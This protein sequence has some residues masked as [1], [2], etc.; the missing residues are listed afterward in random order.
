MKRFTLMVSFLTLLCLNIVAQNFELYENK[1]IFSNMFTE[2]EYRTSTSV[3]PLCT[4]ELSWNVAKRV[5]SSGYTLKNQQTTSPLY[6][7][8]VEDKLYPYI[9]SNIYDYAQIVSAKTG[10]DIEVVT[11]NSRG[12][13]MELRKRL[14]DLRP[15]LIGCFFIGDVPYAQYQIENDDNSGVNT[16]FPC[17]LYFM[18]LDGTWLDNCSN[19]G[20]EGRFT[21]GAD[22]IF[23]WHIG[24]VAPDIFIGR[25][26][27][28]YS[29]D[30]RPFEQLVNQSLERL[31]RYWE[32]PDGIKRKA[33]SYIN[34]DW[35]T[36]Y[37][38]ARQNVSRLSPLENAGFTID[39]YNE[40]NNP[41]NI[42][43]GD[44][45][46]K[47]TS[48]QYSFVHLWAHSHWTNHMFGQ[49]DINESYLFQSEIYASP[50]KA[51]MYNLFCCS[52]TRWTEKSYLGGAYLFGPKSN[53]LALVGST[54]VGSMYDSAPFHGL[55][56]YGLSIGE[57]YFTWWDMRPHLMRTN[58]HSDEDIS[59]YYGLT[60]L[61]D[62]LVR[63][64]NPID[65]Y[66]QD[67]PDDDG[68]MPNAMDDMKYNFWE[69]QDIWIRNQRDGGTEHQNPVYREGKPV[70]V[71]ARIRNR[72]AKT[73][74]Q[75]ATVTLRWSQ[76][77][78]SLDYDSFCGKNKLDNGVATGGLIGTKGIPSVRPNESVVICF[79]WYI[80]DP[81][82]YQQYT[83]D[84]WHYC[85]LAEI[86][87]IQEP[88]SEKMHNLRDYVKS[89]NNVAMKNIY[90]IEVSDDD[91]SLISGVISIHNPSIDNRIYKIELETF[92]KNTLQQTNLCTKAEV[93]L[94]P[95]RMLYHS[96][97]GN[98]A[99]LRNLQLLKSEGRLVAQTDLASMDKVCLAPGE[100]GLLNVKF[101][102][103]EQMADLD[104]EYI[105][106]VLLKD[107]ETGEL[108]GGETYV[109]K[110]K[111]RPNFDVV[112][113]HK[114][115]EGAVH[116]VAQQISE[117]ATY[118]WRDSEGELLSE[119]LE[120]TTKTSAP[121]QL[122]VEAKSDGVKGE[123][124][125]EGGSSSLAGL[126]TISPN[127]AKDYLDVKVKME[128]EASLIITSVA[129]GCSYI[130]PILKEGRI[131]VG[132]LPRGK[133]L[134]SLFCKE[135]MYDKQT[136]ILE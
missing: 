123:A 107:Q 76:A 117:P 103:K 62:P 26:P 17:D 95:D 60:I 45:L 51:L 124:L 18:D 132:S 56:A 75:G 134:V 116:L 40:A 10:Y 25:L 27:Y 121:V 111:S 61:G 133:Y 59:W 131:D 119:G 99:E 91:N 110:K 97:V 84:A 67:A 4:R 114:L 34:H 125:F 57:S 93:S 79:P 52:A 65:L 118:R 74:P 36:S 78:I 126:L 73:S 98:K 31:I 29:L 92:D 102:F 130:Y 120:F 109:I 9:R 72:G 53:T 81:K 48:G 5:Y 101:N 70:F 115:E 49:E 100:M 1:Q 44:Y 19:P 113:G 83:K 2:E 6:L 128:R 46:S 85:L 28:Y 47:I 33:L 41:R 39:A 3:A 20:S 108:V 90:N 8:V 32:Q 21:L 22:G 14:S 15:R 54:K 86:E 64:G 7:L 30:N 68:S 35:A 66:M 82:Q 71:Y 23:D 63:L 69:S 77:G 135:E 122:E 12:S 94:I 136:I 129:D 13:A 42:S 87:S 127:P 11:V 24:S 96:M 58:S 38:Y 37:E 80:K 55:L 112:I 106:R 105:C 104:G 89:Y 16:T 50:I 43:A 88:I